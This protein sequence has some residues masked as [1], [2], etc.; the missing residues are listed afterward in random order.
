MPD[1]GAHRVPGHARPPGGHPA[2]GDPRRHPGRPQRPGPRA[3]ME[4]YGI[5]PIDLVAVNLY[6]FS[7][8]PS[9]ELIDIGG[10]T[11]VRAAAKNHEHVDRAGRSRP[12]TTPVLAE[13]RDRRRRLR[14]DP[15]PPGPRRVRPHRGL[16]RRHRGVVR[17]PTGRPG[18]PTGGRCPPR[19]TCRPPGPPSCA[20]AR[21]RTSTVPAT[22][23]R[24]SCWDSAIQH[25]G[26]EMSLP[27]RLRRRRRLAPGVVAGR[28]AR[29]RWSSSTPT[30]AGWRCRRHHRGRTSG[31]TRATR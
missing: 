31:H 29:P 6:P 25:G 19:S 12:T 24:E 13:L 21:T 15:P 3:D 7:S 26:K 8:D 5:T 4:N 9:I 11:M 23:A 20:T 22:A 1:R 16:R 28:R 27:Q 30:R 17:P 2:P 18:L 14:R 10:P